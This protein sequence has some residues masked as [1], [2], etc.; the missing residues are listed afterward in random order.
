MRHFDWYQRSTNPPNF[1]LFP[2]PTTPVTTQVFSA[3]WNDSSSSCHVTKGY[4]L[5][6]SL[7]QSF[8]QNLKT[9]IP[10]P[11]KFEQNYST[12]C[13]YAN[14]HISEK[15]KTKL[16]KSD[17]HKLSVEQG[18]AIVESVFN[19]TSSQSLV[20]VPQVYFMGFPR[21]GST[22]LYKMLIRHPLIRGGINKEPHWWAKYDYSFQF[23]NNVLSILRY[24]SF[25]KDSFNYIKN[26]RN[27]LL[28]DGSQSLVWDTRKTGNLCF[29]PQLFSEMFP[30]AKF[31]VLMRD[32]VERLYSD[33]NY[34]CEV[35]SKDHDLP[36]EFNTD[37]ADW[38]HRKVSQELEKMEK[39][40]SVSSLEE[41]AHHGLSGSS[42]GLCGHVRLGISLYHV[43]IKRW[44][45][46]TSRK[47]FLF[48]TTAEM[49]SE[50]LMVMQ[51]TWD[52]LG[53]PKQ[54]PKELDDILYQHLHSSQSSQSS[55]IG[56]T[57][58]TEV[59]LRKFFQ[60]HND[61]LATLLGEDQLKFSV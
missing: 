39:C 17:Q 6:T 4:H 59:M 56:M 11:D 1:S 38:F 5:S 23:P 26:N 31:I 43:H 14:L 52:F 51:K 44:L 40:L 7:L 22:Q 37:R 15:T 32:P 49:A 18:E 36:E 58:V 35:A 2:A 13:W 53:L 42:E 60:P 55:K 27:T 3:K 29:L 28:I 20:C 61:V 16:F 50:P 57:N 30:N 34:L 9:I 19:Q 21:S 33:F 54:D 12:P 47:Q 8:I 46:E 45:R 41:C 48:L 10:T 25:F 24:I